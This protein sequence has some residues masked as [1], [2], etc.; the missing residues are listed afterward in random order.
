M[1][2]SEHLY[3]GFLV[4]AQHGPND[5]KPFFGFI[6]VKMTAAEYAA[7]LHYKVAQVIAVEQGC[8]PTPIVCCNISDLP[9]FIGRGLM[10]VRKNTGILA[11]LA[12]DV[13]PR[14][15][16]QARQLPDPV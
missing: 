11:A 9:E 7:K 6:T 2:T 4:I 1:E 12:F 10:D 5:G 15:Y 8:T 16:E 13:E 14:H 3:N